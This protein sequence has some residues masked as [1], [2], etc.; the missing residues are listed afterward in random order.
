MPI[1]LR[2]PVGSESSRSR[3]S[4]SHRPRPVQGFH[5]PDGLDNYPPHRAAKHGQL[6]YLRFYIDHYPQQLTRLSNRMLKP[7]MYPLSVAAKH[8]RVDA[9]RLLIDELPMISRIERNV[10]FA[11]DKLDPSGRTALLHA[12]DND[13]DAVVFELIKYGGSDPWRPMLDV[14]TGFF[15][16][17]DF[18]NALLYAVHAG[19]ARCVDELLAWHAADHI[20]DSLYDARTAAYALGDNVIA[21]KIKKH[22]RQLRPHRRHRD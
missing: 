11:V 10:R 22:M 14:K 8:G 18:G 6:E 19:A 7:N 21:D 12:I 9:V 17:R 4:A 15:Q 3:R 13:Q 2:L 16:R 1:N 20:P 5:I